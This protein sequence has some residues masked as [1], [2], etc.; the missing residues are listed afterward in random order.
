MNSLQREFNSIQELQIRGLDFGLV[1]NQKPDFGKNESS[2]FFYRKGT[3]DLSDVGHDLRVGEYFEILCDLALEI[4]KIHKNGYVHR[5]IKP[6]NVMINQMI[7]GK[8]FAGIVDFGMA[9][10]MNRKQNEEGVV[11]GTQ[12]FR[13]PSQLEANE[14][15]RPGQDWF[16]YSITALYLL[17]GGVDS[18]QAEINRSINGVNL[19]FENLPAGPIMKFSS[20]LQEMVRVSTS[21]KFT[22]EELEECANKLVNS[23]SKINKKSFNHIKNRNKLISE[24]TTSIVKHDVLLIIDETNSLSKDID[25]IKDTIYEVIQEFN[26]RMDLR[27]DLWTVRDYARKNAANSNHE[28]VRNVGYRLTAKTLAHAIDEI[29]AD[30]VQHDEAEAYEMGFEW[31]LGNMGINRPSKWKT[32][33]SSTN[34]VILAGDAYAHGWLRKNWWAIFYGD[35]KINPSDEKKKKLFQ[36]RHP[37]SLSNND[38]ERTELE[39]EEPKKKRKLINLVRKKKKFLMG[40]VECK[41]VLICERS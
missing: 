17:R 27:I 14:R 25:N 11:G 35:C 22:L 26:G 1:P 4:S 3:H 40:W 28:T 39:K 36:E 41:C 13:H 31:A 8:K 18:M 38:N 23:A 16:S 2:I 37:N 9:L 21:A 32:R 34:T 29:A 24:S 30:A 19:N 33:Y 12:H 7:N 5:D 10:K 15:A 20:L 6:G